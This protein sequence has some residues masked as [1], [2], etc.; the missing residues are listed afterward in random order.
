MPGRHEVRA[1]ARAQQHLIGGGR[2]RVGLLL[3]EHE[4]EQQVTRS[5]GQR[6]VV[7][8]IAGH[9]IAHALALAG[10]AAD[11]RARAQGR[12][13]E[14]PLRVQRDSEHVPQGVGAQWLLELQGALEQPQRLAA[15]VARIQRADAQ[16]GRA[17][18]HEQV[19]IEAIV[20]A[21]DVMRGRGGQRDG[22][23]RAAVDALEPD[24]PG[25]DRGARDEAQ[26]AHGILDEAGQARR[27][28]RRDPARA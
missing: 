20:H 18:D 8:D 16:R 10:I 21:G 19:E 28:L 27:A 2:E 22:R 4:G 23:A 24:R 17:G 26:G 7:H 3:V 25:R 12:E 9:E 5:R 13:C 15:G 1:R 11:Q 14:R 6:C